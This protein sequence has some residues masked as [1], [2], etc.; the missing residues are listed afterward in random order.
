MITE[1]QRIL[2]SMI[3]A[4]WLREREAAGE[5]AD[6]GHIVTVSRQCGSYGED[7]A[8]LIANQ[9]EVPYFDKKLVEQIAQSAGVDADLF[10]ELEQKIHRVKPTWLETVFTDRPWLQAKYNKNLVNVL[11]GI[12]RVGGV[13]LG[14]G[15]NFVLGQSAC[16]RLRIVAP[17]PIRVARYSASYDLG[18]KSAEEAVQKI[19]MER[20]NFVESIYGGD[21]DNPANYDLTINTER[22]SAQTAAQLAL[23]AAKFGQFCAHLQENSK[24]VRNDTP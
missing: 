23:A 3:D 17:L 5:H 19:D 21:V 9:L 8:Q 13:I 10:R 7:I 22:F 4:H 1:N 15:A 24:P 16:F 20:S 12:S 2:Q 6:P 11:L 14:R 18:P